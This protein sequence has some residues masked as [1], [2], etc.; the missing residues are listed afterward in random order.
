MKLEKRKNRAALSKA[1]FRKKTVLI[2]SQ[3]IFLW[4]GFTRQF[5]LTDFLFIFLGK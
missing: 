4:E 1:V 3:Y 5:L 2:K